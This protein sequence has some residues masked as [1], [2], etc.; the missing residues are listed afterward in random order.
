MS[1]LYATH[2]HALIVT[3]PADTDISCDRRPAAVVTGVPGDHPPA[4]DLAMPGA[5]VRLTLDRE[6]TAGQVD[7]LRA[8]LAEEVAAFV[9][10]I[11]QW[12]ADLHAREASR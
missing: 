10:D 9:A 12:A 1:P 2:P 4:L 7:Q 5:V 3:L 8:C 11:A 6:L